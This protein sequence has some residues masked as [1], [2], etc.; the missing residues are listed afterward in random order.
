M[1]A[2]FM[3]LLRQRDQILDYAHIKNEMD[4]LI[5]INRKK[6]QQQQNRKAHEIT[7]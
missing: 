2:A 5:G 1:N 6:P 7:W 3:R 4:P